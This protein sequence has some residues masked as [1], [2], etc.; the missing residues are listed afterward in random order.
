MRDVQYFLVYLR[1]P[2]DRELV[3]EFLSKAYPTT[4]HVLLQGKVCRPEWLVE[5]ECVAVKE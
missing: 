5:M 2:S 1:D 4:P 3:E